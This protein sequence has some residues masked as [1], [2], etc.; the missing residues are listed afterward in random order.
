MFKFDIPVGCRH[1]LRLI[2]NSGYDAYIVGGCVRDTL[3][4]KEP[5]DWDICTSAMPAQVLAIMAKNG[6][7]TSET[8]LQH[9]TVTIHFENANYEVTTFRTDG[10]Y[11]DN[12]RP[13]RVEFVG[14]IIEDLSRRDLTINAMAYSECSGIIDPWGGY[15]DL[16][17]GIIRCVRNPDDRFRE[18]ALRIMRALRFAA[19]Y[20]FK[21]EEKT[22]AAIH[23]NKELLKNISAERIQSELTK[24]LC[25]EGTLDILLEYSDVMAVI[26]PELKPCIG[27]DQKNKYH[28]YNVYDH[29]AHAVD[30]FKG[31]DISV[32]MALLLHDIGKPECYTEDNNGGHFY[33]HGVVSHRLAKDVMERL[34]FDNKTEEEVLTL[35]L[36]HD[37]G[38]HPGIKSVKRWLN[39]IGPEMLN[40][41]IY[42]KIADIGAHSDIN[43]E[44]R[45]NDC[46][47]VKLL[48]KHILDSQQCFTLKDLAINGFNI[49]GL[50]LEPGPMVGKVLKH[51][52][53]M[54]LDG[55]IENDFH[56]LMGEA[57]KYLKRRKQNDNPE[58]LME[59][60]K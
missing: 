33:A 9:G 41:L 49:I 59:T 32:K 47:S 14:D 51:L 13:D 5:N 8:G 42:V 2:E 6:I 23:R 31:T 37:A 43:Q 53:D 21:I 45:R 56:A 50:G 29:I 54:V 15:T 27:F 19:T 58:L 38:I 60:T 16:C 17:E 40:K 18:D 28:I 1:V 20:G 30:N 48:A 12:R 39:K 35:V 46:L 7:K 4:Y 52:L 44:S 55:E 34:R 3:C 24:M 26:I 25:G 10:E 57:N 22:A 11:T 36:Y